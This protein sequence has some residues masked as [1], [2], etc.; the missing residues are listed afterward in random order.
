MCNRAQDVTVSNQEYTAHCLHHHTG[1]V[2]RH[3]V[4]FPQHV[5]ECSSAHS[6]S[7]KI[8]NNLIVYT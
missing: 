2:I 8:K 1:T 6:W 7:C 4:E 3:A 5:Q